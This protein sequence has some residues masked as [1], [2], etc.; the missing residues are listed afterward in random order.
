MDGIN[1]LQIKNNATQIEVKN[2]INQ[3]GAS[4]TFFRYFKKRS[5]D[6]IE[7]HIHTIL[8]Y[9]L[10]NVVGYGH[11]E[12]ENNKTWLGIVLDDKNR[13][14]GYGKYLMEHLINLFLKRQDDSLYLTVD[15]KNKAAIKLFEN[16]GF[17]TE[18]IINSRSYLMKLNKSQI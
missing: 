8:L 12:K 11:L 18:S 7:N 4:L 3:C 14:K 5:F 9:E 6:I 1:N 15:I 13:G 17:R 16:S 2:F 10:N